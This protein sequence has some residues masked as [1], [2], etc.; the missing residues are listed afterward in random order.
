MRHLICFFKV[1][2]L[3]VMDLV[4]RGRLARQGGREGGSQE[5]FRSS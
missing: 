2:V 3:L 1:I 5:Y 4:S